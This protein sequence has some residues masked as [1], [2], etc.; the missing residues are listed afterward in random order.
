MRVEELF[1]QRL[2]VDQVTGVQPLGRQ[3]SVD[4]QHMWRLVPGAGERLVDER[5]VVDYLAAARAGVGGHDQRRGCVVDARRETR[6]RKTAEHDRVNRAEPRAGEH[7]KHRL[8]DH[9]QVDQHAVAPL[10]AERA[11]DR[12]HPVDFGVQLGVRVAPFDA[13]L[14]RYVDE[15]VLLGAFGEMPVHRVMAQVGPTADEPARKRGI[16]AVEHRLERRL[17]MD[18]PRF[19][20]PEVFRGFDGTAVELAVTGHRRRS[21]LRYVVSVTVRVRT[22]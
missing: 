14:R 7:R 5:R 21:F 4:P 11:H 8:G 13:S 20:A 15:C 3:L 9:R 16:R 18:A 22:A 6:R 17:P 19:V 10:D 12:G 1:A 2:V